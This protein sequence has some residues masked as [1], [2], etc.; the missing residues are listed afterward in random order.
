MGI[1]SGE[2]EDDEMEDEITAVG[3]ITLLYVTLVPPLRIR[4]LVRA[5]QTSTV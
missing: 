4:G 1:T 2:M 5:V 3:L